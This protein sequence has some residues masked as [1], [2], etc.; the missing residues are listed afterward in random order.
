[1]REIAR[2]EGVLALWSGIA[3]RIA[4]RTLQ[5]AM[6]WTLFEFMYQGRLV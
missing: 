6:T 2:Q 4:R 5:Q 3:P 1:M